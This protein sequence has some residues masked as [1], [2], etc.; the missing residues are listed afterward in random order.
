LEAGA[1]IKKDYQDFVSKIDSMNFV[2][3][4][5][6]VRG[7]QSP[8]LIRKHNRS[9]FVFITKIDNEEK[10]VGY[11]AY[12]DSYGTNHLKRLS[13]ANEKLRNMIL[14][15]ELISE[16]LLRNSVDG[17]NTIYEGKKGIEFDL[18]EDLFIIQIDDFSRSCVIE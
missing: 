6:E 1:R 13:S 2:I 11:Y 18:D 15:N 3:N 14:R 17:W 7:V 9:Y 12:K 5:I 8:V 10:I 16:G 4:E